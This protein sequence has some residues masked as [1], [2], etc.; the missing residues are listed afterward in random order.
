MEHSI[1]Y[2]M[3]CK[4]LLRLY[5]DLEQCRDAE[6]QMQITEDIDLLERAIS[7]LQ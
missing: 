2:Q 3:F 5:I 6:L 1:E 4:E 7:T